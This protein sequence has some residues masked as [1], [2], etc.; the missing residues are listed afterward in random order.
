MWGTF[1]KI[2]SLIRMGVNDMGNEK[3]LVT[4]R[5]YA[6]SVKTLARA[7][8]KSNALIAKGYSGVEIRKIGKS[9]LVLFD[10]PSYTLL[11]KK[12]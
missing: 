3:W 1:K 11:Q 4:I 2:V 12:A 5:R 8:K 7:E 6:T 10:L 9:I